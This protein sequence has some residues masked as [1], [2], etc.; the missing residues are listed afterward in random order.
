MKKH[1][2]KSKSTIMGH[3]YQNIK[4]QRSTQPTKDASVKKYCEPTTTKSPHSANIAAAKLIFSARIKTRTYQ[5]LTNSLVPINFKERKE[6]RL[7]NL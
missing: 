6:I 1:L 2:H 7:I 5:H 3:I 4:N